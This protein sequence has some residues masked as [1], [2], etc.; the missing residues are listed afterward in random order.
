[1]LALGAMIMVCSGAAALDCGLPAPGSPEI[2]VGS[3]PIPTLVAPRRAQALVRDVLGGELLD[4]ESSPRSSAAY[5]S[6]QFVLR[7][8]FRFR[9]APDDSDDEGAWAR[10]SK[11]DL[12]RFL[13]LY[14]ELDKGVQDGL[15]SRSLA[16]YAALPRSP[17]DEGV[18]DGIFSRSLAA[19][20]A[21]PRS[22]AASGALPCMVIDG[23]V[24]L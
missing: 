9:R 22:L 8:P 2:V 13:P 17:I 5:R 19:Y 11:L 6:R 10:R 3:P 14:A 1:M 7:F 15:Y 18:Q 12:H 16:A 20:A 24:Q 21:L 4:E 23:G